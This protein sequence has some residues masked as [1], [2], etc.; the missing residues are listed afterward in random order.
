MKEYA[1]LRRDEEI[2]AEDRRNLERK[3]VYSYLAEKFLKTRGSQG[4]CYV[5]CG[6]RRRRTHSAR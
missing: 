2:A 1:T 3:R 4:V 5:G 6:T